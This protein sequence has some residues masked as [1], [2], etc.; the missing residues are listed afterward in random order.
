MEIDL[1]F[2]PRYELNLSVKL[3]LNVMFICEIN[4]SQIADLHQVLCVSWPVA[5]RCLKLPSPPSY[6]DNYLLGWTAFFSHCRFAKRVLK[7]TS[8]WVQFHICCRCPDCITAFNIICNSFRSLWTPTSQT[9][10]SKIMGINMA[11]LLWIKLL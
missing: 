5:S 2:Y 6:K 8:I 4:R 10:N 7:I 11:Y 1:A 9:F 3:P